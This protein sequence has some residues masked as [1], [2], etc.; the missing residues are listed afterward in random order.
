MDYLK[1]EKYV[2]CVVNSNT[3]IISGP[4]VFV[5]LASR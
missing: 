5:R 1:A 4:K 2:Y 3:L